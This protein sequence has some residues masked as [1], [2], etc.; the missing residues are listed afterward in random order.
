MMELEMERGF[1]TATLV[2]WWSHFVFLR[3]PLKIWCSFRTHGD[4]VLS[5]GCG[6]LFERRLREQSMEI[7]DPFIDTVFPDLANIG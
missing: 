6:K 2:P 5:E 1:G 7:S 3:V 4:Y